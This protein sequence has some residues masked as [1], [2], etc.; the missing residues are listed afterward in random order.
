MVTH[1]AYLLAAVGRLCEFDPPLRSRRSSM[2]SVLSIP[3]GT[4]SKNRL[5]PES[6]D[7]PVSGTV[8]VF[9]KTRLVKGLGKLPTN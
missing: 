5:S 2:P 9:Y 1:I 3:I 7:K 8:A 6:V 4:G